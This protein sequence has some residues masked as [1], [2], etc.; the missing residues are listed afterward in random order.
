MD[1]LCD[2][3]GGR[4]HR[5]RWGHRRRV[6]AGKL[7]WGDDQAAIALLEEI[8]KGAELSADVANE[9]VHS[10][11]K[12]GVARIPAV[13]GQ[14]CRRRA[15]HAESDRHHHR[16]SPMGADHTAGPIVMPVADGARA[17]QNAQI[18]NAVCDSSGFCQFQQPSMEEMRQYFNA[19]FGLA[20]SPQ[21]I[22]QY[23]WQC[24]RT[25]GRSTA[26]PG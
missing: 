15:A 4:H 7:R 20:L 26:R 13:K 17:S 14:G 21:D 18:V 16:R 10:G 8:D 12:Y 25:S 19:M 6:E 22:V 11:T 24:C 3:L 2:E 23:G 1:R 5:D 9:V